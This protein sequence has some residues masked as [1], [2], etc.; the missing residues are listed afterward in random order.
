VKP[1]TYEVVVFDDG[2]SAVSEFDRGVPGNESALVYVGRDFRDR[3]AT[4]RLL[5]ALRSPMSV[6]TTPRVEEAPGRA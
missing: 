6:F 4:A 2:T 5:G 1:K 3:E